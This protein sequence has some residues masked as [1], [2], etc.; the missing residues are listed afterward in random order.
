MQKYFKILFS[1]LVIVLS[2]ISV[3]HAATWT[4]GLPQVPVN[5]KPL[6]KVW[7]TIANDSSEMAEV[8]IYEVDSVQ[9]NT[10]TLI[11]GIGTKIP[12][13]P[14]AVI[15]PLG[16]SSKLK[17]ND[18]CIGSSWGAS[19]VIGRVKSIEAGQAT[20]RYKW[21]S[22]LTDKLMDHAEP[23]VKGVNPMAWVIYRNSM[24][25]PYK[26]L[27]IAKGD[28][29]VW[30][31]TD[32]GHIEVSPEAKVLPLDMAQNGF[33]VGQTVYVYQWGF[34]YKPGTVKKIVEPY[35]QYEIK[36]VGKDTTEVYIFSEVAAKI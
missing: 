35:H 8:G 3:V 20:L 1:A 10:A 34:G 14:G 32:S 18:L 7:A 9:G 36:L 28:G 29:K 12:N 6:D 24:N 21:A 11:D 17:P 31:S 19:K 26:G 22:T 16:D 4:A 27:V 33:E 2:T 25:S 5:A 30:I 15:H 23:L 13:V